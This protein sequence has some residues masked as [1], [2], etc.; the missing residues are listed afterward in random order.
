VPPSPAHCTAGTARG[1]STPDG[2][3][4]LLCK[5]IPPPSA[6]PIRA[7]FNGAARPVVCV[8]EGEDAREDEG[9][10]LLTTG[11]GAGV[12]VSGAAVVTATLVRA[13]VPD[14]V[15]PTRTTAAATTATTG[16]T[17]RVSARPAG[18]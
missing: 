7:Q 10:L 6:D 3:D 14:P 4:P 12:D 5:M 18:R 9:M 13:D 8:A 15:Q 1:S 16:S 11:A 2:S 17:A